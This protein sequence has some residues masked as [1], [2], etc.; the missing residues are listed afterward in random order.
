[1][2]YEENV[3]QYIV[4]STDIQTKYNFAQSIKISFV[5]ESVQTNYAADVLQKALSEQGYIV[6][7][8]KPDFL[9]TLKVDSSNLSSEAFQ[10]N[11]GKSNIVI[12]GGDGRGIIYG[13][14]SL[15]EDLMNKIPLKEIIAKKESPKLPF[16]AIKFDL[17]WDT[18]RHSYAL[19]LHQETCRDINYWKAFLDMMCQ[20]RFNVLQLYNLHPY[21]FLIKLKNFPEASPWNDKEM[22]DW[23]KLFAGIFKLAKERGN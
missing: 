9:I 6:S 18:Y 20:N 5:D 22:D 11:P 19:S 21:T 14:N 12:K 16:R 10:I 4:F 3:F 13:C 23:K 1:M 2:N 17:P 15:A 7:E 8:D